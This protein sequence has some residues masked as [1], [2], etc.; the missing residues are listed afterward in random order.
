MNFFI[1]RYPLNDAKNLSPFSPKLPHMITCASWHRSLFLAEKCFSDATASPTFT[2]THGR[3]GA[4]TRRGDCRVWIPISCSPAGTRS[5]RRY[6]SCV[7]SWQ[8]DATIG[9]WISFTLF[10]LFI[11]EDSWTLIVRLLCHHCESTQDL[12][13]LRLVEIIGAR[14][15]GRTE[16]INSLLKALLYLCRRRNTDM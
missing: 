3:I 9:C 8:P 11:L 13:K 5:E 7:E 4:M 6:T 1:H 15:S 16:L 2:V 10:H 14:P 12:T